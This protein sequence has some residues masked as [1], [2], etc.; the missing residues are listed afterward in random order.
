MYYIK[1]EY[2]I[3]EREFPVHSYFEYHL[4]FKFQKKMY[5]TVHLI[6]IEI[7]IT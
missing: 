7:Q 6:L 1:E 2:L 4:S 5:L 3:N